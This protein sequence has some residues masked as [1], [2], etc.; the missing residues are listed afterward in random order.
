MDD[1]GRCV[2]GNMPNCSK[3]TTYGLCLK[4]KFNYVFN[5]QLTACQPPLS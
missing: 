2:K 3:Y 1:N 5:Y 4:C